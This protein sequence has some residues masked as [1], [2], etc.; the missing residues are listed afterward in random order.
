VP[1]VTN[2]TPFTIAKLATELTT[3][4]I[5]MGYAAATTESAALADKLNQN[6]EPATVTG[7]IQQIYK[8]RTPTEDLIGEILDTEWVAL[9][10][11]KKEQL[12]FLLGIP[13]AKTGSQRFR[14]HMASIFAVG[15]ASRTSMIAMAS[16][17]CSRAEALWHDVASISADEVDKALGRSS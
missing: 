5:N 6:P 10:A 7:G 4:P 8:T 15:S 11:A 3:D 12:R 16:R 2:Q 14:D 1:I 17:D 9:S 13:W